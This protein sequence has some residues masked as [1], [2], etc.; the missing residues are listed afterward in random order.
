MKDN[1]YATYQVD[2]VIR[3]AYFIIKSKGRSK[4]KG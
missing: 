4:G 3:A 2:T 1:L